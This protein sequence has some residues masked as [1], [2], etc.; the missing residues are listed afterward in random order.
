MKFCRFAK[1]PHTIRDEICKLIYYPHYPLAEAAAKFLI[2]R[3]DLYIS[4]PNQ[5]EEYLKML[6]FFEKKSVSFY[7]QIF[8]FN[9]I[10][11][12]LKYVWL[13]CRS[14]EVSSTS[15]HFLLKPSLIL[16]QYFETSPCIYQF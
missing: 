1:L 12:Q 13:N 5:S 10:H 7:F 14:N 16:C 2:S 3:M 11:F 4:D 6:I 9:L 15:I 8:F